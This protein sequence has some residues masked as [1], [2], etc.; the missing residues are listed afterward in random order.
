MSSRRRLVLV[1]DDSPDFLA[2][3][4]ELLTVE[5][6]CEVATLDQSEAVLEQVGSS[7]APD[8]I[9]LDVAFHHGPSGLAIADQLDAAGLGGIP[10]LFCTALTD[11]DLGPDA[12]ALAAARDQRILYKPFDVDDLLQ[13]VSELLQPDAAR[14]A[15]SVRSARSA[16]DHPGDPGPPAP[17]RIQPP[18]ADPARCP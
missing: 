11:R 4:R 18:P 1:V 14:S 12:L 3:M 9:I 5:G 6:G 16:P 13:V 2:L 17:R 7:I 15:R 8:L 10:L